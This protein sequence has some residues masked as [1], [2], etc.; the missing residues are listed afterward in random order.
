MRWGYSHAQIAALCTEHGLVV[1][2]TEYTSGVIAQKLTNYMRLPFSKVTWALTFPLR[3]L[4]ILDP[5]VTR[6]F[7]YPYFGIGVVS[8]KPAA[9]VK[10][11]RSTA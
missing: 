3:P 2:S 9:D 6:L 8:E 7:R 1:T 11:K 4:T 5:Y 10:T